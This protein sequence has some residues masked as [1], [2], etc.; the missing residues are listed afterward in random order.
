MYSQRGESS[1]PCPTVGTLWLTQGGERRTPSCS[2]VHAPP[3]S[4]PTPLLTRQRQSQRHSHPQPRPLLLSPQPHPS[5]DLYSRCASSFGTS[6]R[7][8]TLEEKV[9]IRPLSKSRN[10][11]CPWGQRR[12]ELG[13]R[14]RRGKMKVFD[15]KKLLTREFFVDFVK[16]CVSKFFA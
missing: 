12:V 13:G 14:V 11:S 16:K 15:V 4:W 8:T 3:I 10:R 2:I 5:V 6:T 9:F 1:P 7:L